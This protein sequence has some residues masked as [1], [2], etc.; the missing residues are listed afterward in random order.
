MLVI[1]NFLG[2]NLSD[3]AGFM[4]AI[5]ST[6]KEMRSQLKTLECKS[7]TRFQLTFGKLT[8]GL[9]RIKGLGVPL[10]CLN[11]VKLALNKTCFFA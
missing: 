2:T 9:M 6:R 7:D 10:R 5:A 11:S 3:K 4:N 8:A 1:L